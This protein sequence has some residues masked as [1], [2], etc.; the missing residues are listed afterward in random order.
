MEST[1]KYFKTS[2][3]WGFIVLWSTLD[4]GV[5][6]LH[7]PWF[8]A[9]SHLMFEWLFAFHI[10]VIGWC[11]TSKGFPLIGMRPSNNVLFLSRIWCRI[12]DP[13]RR[14]LSA[15][16]RRASLRPKGLAG[17]HPRW[18]WGAAF[19]QQVESAWRWHE[20][21]IAW[22]AWSTTQNQLRQLLHHWCFRANQRFFFPYPLWLK[23]LAQ[24]VSA[25][26]SKYSNT[27]NVVSRRTGLGQAACRVVFP[28]TK[29]FRLIGSSVS[30]RLFLS[31]ITLSYFLVLLPLSKTLRGHIVPHFLRF[32]LTPHSLFTALRSLFGHLSYSLPLI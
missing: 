22:Q 1:P 12:R 2:L 21:G 27:T 10:V 20:G 30:F 7:R 23:P 32:P 26:N 9:R 16:S 4:S 8:L 14:T 28:L 19:Y 18:A 15:S 6:V 11:F 25:Q 29:F 24:A 13:N 31:P 5:V 3:I 17:I